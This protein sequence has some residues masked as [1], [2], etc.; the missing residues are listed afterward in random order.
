MLP[1]SVVVRWADSLALT[2]I[3]CWHIVRVV[4]GVSLE[5]WTEKEPMMDIM[6]YIIMW[7]TTGEDEPQTV[8][9]TR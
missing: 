4:T 5:A 1:P 7:Y 9:L 3:T 8:V 6:T 2:I